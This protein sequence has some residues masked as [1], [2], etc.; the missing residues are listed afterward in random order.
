[1]KVHVIAGSAILYHAT[2]LYSAVKILESKHFLLRPAVADDEE[3]FGTA[4]YFLSTARSILSE[5][6]NSM[7]IY[8]LFQLDGTRIGQN[9]K[10]VPV[11]FF[12]EDDYSKVDEKEDRVLSTRN[13]LSI[14]YVTAIH[15]PI[16]N[17]PKKRIGVPVWG[18]AQRIKRLGKRLGIPVYFYKQDRLTSLHP[19]NRVHIP[20]ESIQ[21]A[22]I[23]FPT[24]TGTFV[25]SQPRNTGSLSEHKLLAS[26]V[27]LKI[28]QLRKTNYKLTDWYVSH[29]TLY[30]F[31]V[32][33]VNN[34][35][36]PYHVPILSKMRKHRWDTHYLV[37][38]VRAKLMYMFDN[39]LLIDI[40]YDSLTKPLD[41]KQQSLLRGSSL[42]QLKAEQVL[43]QEEHLDYADKLKALANVDVFS[44]L[45]QKYAY[46][47][48]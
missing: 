40:V 48:L 24:G 31:V 39:T 46:Y 29:S 17:L 25:R 3:H 32:S 19:K 41:N 21:E 23:P 2:P 18:L 42:V 26:L 47:I 12:E 38:Y 6:F 34:I 37:A 1:M 14:K 36:N 8:V 33:I 43:I 5:Y 27:L 30:R 15:I 44:H 4:L 35:H 20:F 13:T 22:P 10:V 7:F 9:H 11:E 28:P 45:D 16:G